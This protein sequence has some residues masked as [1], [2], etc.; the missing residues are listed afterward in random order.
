MNL[1]S[2]LNYS[3]VLF[4]GHPNCSIIKVK[5]SLKYSA[6]NS[7]HKHNVWTNIQLLQWLPVPSGSDKKI[8]FM[9]TLCF[10]WYNT[11][12]QI[13]DFVHQ[14]INKQAVGSNVNYKL[15]FLYVYCYRHKLYESRTIIW[16]IINS[17][18]Y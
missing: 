18:Q 13:T 12:V 14:K 9:Q 10:T 1:S 16:K 15:F 8:L 7:Y 5:T 4:S 11:S 2:R 17:I 3:D 6:K